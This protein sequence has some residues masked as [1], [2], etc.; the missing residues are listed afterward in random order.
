MYF[1]CHLQSDVFTDE[2]EEGFEYVELEAYK[3]CWL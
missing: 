1:P 2:N 3:Q